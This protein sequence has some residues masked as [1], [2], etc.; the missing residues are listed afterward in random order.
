M[1]R[2]PFAVW[3]PEGTTPGGAIVPRVA[4]LHVDAVGNGLPRPHDGLEWHFWISYTGA[5]YQ[6]VDTERRADANYKA[7][8][9]A[10]SI[11]TEGKGDGEWTPAQLKS[12][13]R[14]LRWL[15]AT[16]PKIKLARCPTWDGAG[17]G[18]HTM[19][20]AP[21]PWTPVAKS[22]PGP[23]RKVQ[24]DKV[25]LPSLAGPPQP[26]PNP[27]PLKEDRMA[28]YVLKPGEEVCLPLTGPATVAFAT[29]AFQSQ[30]KGVTARVVVGPQ[31]HAPLKT[32]SEAG[33]GDLLFVPVGARPSFATTA[34]DQLLVV[35]HLGREN[36]P[37][38]VAVERTS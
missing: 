33:L 19:F 36:V 21:G 8:S 34:T 4:I 15:N 6:L 3:R 14:L 10:I 32:A 17:I 16:H 30:A 28:L 38:G 27:I 23:K 22:C 35:Q 5:V 12:I 13:E 2:C 31:W 9:F 7:N 18:H 11:E 1:A 37:L 25:V 26:S 29:D 24:F 20:G